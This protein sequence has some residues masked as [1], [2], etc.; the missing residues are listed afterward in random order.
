M[1]PSQCTGVLLLCL[2]ACGHARR[3]S[4]SAVRHYRNA[5]SA[6]AELAAYMQ[7]LDEAEPHHVCVTGNQA[8]HAVDSFVLQGT[9]ESRSD[10]P[11]TSLIS[12]ESCTAQEA[13]VGK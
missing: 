7:S 3:G 11:L 13:L 5:Q 8:A 1:N 6:A 4:N 12:G 9:G 10:L 2:F